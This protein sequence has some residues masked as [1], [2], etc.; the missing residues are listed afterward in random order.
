MWSDAE[1]ESLGEKQ[2]ME[3]AA[4]VAESATGIDPEGLL[5]LCHS[6]EVLE[7]IKHHARYARQNTVHVTPTALYNGCKVADFNSAWTFED[8]AQFLQNP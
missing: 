1:C 4:K 7:L 6:P 5:K 8:W 2:I 3:K